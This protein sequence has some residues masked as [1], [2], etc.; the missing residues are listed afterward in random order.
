MTAQDDAPAPEAKVHL[1][2][3]SPWIWIIPAVAVFFAG[4][5]ITTALRGGI[6]LPSG[7]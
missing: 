7:S 4:M 3:W 5:L 6:G 1:A 2:K